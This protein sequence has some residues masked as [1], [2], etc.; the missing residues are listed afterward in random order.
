[1][2]LNRAPMLCRWIHFAKSRNRFADLLDTR[3]PWWLMQKRSM[4]IAGHR[5]S[6]ALE[7]EFWTALHEIAE[8]R[9]LTT[10]QFIT[11]IDRRRGQ[12]N[13]ASAVRVA[14]LAY[15]TQVVAS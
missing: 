15:F 2:A 7:A 3:G 12:S 5:T 11:E 10:T 9:G 8:I 13:L 6:L 14:V 1:M 4:T